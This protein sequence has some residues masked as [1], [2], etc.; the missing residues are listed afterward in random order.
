DPPAFSDAPIQGFRL[1]WK[2]AD[3]GRE[4]SV[5]V[6]GRSYRLEG[7][8]KAQQ[9]RLRFLA[10]NRHGPGIASAELGVTTLSDGGKR[11][12]NGKKREKPGG[13]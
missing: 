10:Y 3:T 9:Y 5:D 2:E 7:L 13:G 11:G 4:Q 8:K 6:D 1:F 12:E